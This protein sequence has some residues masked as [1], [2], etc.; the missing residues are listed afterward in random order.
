MN[1]LATKN[2]VLVVLFARNRPEFLGAALRS[3]HRQRFKAFDL[4]VSDNSNDSNKADQNRAICKKFEASGESVSYV[5][6]SGTMQVAGH[7]YKQLSEHA[8]NYEI[9]AVHNDDD[10][11]LSWH[12]DWAV[13]AIRS[14]VDL[15]IGNNA[16]IDGKGKI[17]AARFWGDANPP[18]EKGASALRFW[19]K[20]GFSPYPGYVFRAAKVANIP[21]VETLAID[22][23]IAIWVLACSGKTKCEMRRTFLYRRHEQQL[24]SAGVD[25]E[26]ARHDLRLAIAKKCGWRIFSRDRSF[27]L[28][29]VKSW[30]YLSMARRRSSLLPR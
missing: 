6:Q 16:V 3:I 13:K 10:I 19:L 20:S 21:R 26:G 22:V 25:L 24:S 7:F 4:I 17:T 30:F 29:V 2:S 11:W 23:W 1:R 5:R 14:G 28:R 15:F 27:P 18:P 9:F 8:Y 12:L